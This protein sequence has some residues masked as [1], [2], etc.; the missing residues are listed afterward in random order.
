MND[1]PSATD[2]PLYGQQTAEF[3]LLEDPYRKEV[4][5]DN[6][7]HAKKKTMLHLL[8]IGATLLI[9]NIIG[10]SRADALI[11]DNA[12]DILLIPVIFLAV[13]L[14]AKLQPM[15]SAIAGIAVIVGLTVVNYISFGP[16]TLIAGSIYKILCL[17]FIVKA[18]QQA[19]EAEQAKKELQ[20]FE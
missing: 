2:T 20:L 14:F 10:Y 3:S 16:L 8:Y 7:A 19:K 15:V 5:E 17:Y 12:L 18:V 13:G 11:A 9:S 4:L 6:L 1:Y